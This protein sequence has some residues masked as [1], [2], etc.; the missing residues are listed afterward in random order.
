MASGLGS[1]LDYRESNL[2]IYDIKYI[3]GFCIAVVRD[4]N[5]GRSFSPHSFTDVGV[6]MVRICVFP[7][8]GDSSLNISALDLT[9][10]N[11]I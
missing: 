1:H 9:R 2:S 7:K 3:F 10:F 4:L 6:I 8:S 11:K 5:P